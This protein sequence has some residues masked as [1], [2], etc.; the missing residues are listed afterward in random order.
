MQF[1]VDHAKYQL[2]QLYLDNYVKVTSPPPTIWPIV[3]DI[4][5]SPQRVNIPAQ[6]KKCPFSLRDELE[7]FYTLPQEDS[8]ACDPIQWFSGHC[9]QFLNLSHLAWDFLEIPGEF[10]LTPLNG[11]T[12]YLAILLQSSA[13]AVKCIFSGGHDTISFIMPPL[14]LRPFGPWCLWIRGFTTPVLQ[15]LNFLIINYHRR[16]SIYNLY[17]CHDLFPML[18][19]IHLYFI[20][21]GVT[22]PTPLKTSL[23]MLVSSNHTWLGPT[24]LFQLHLKSRPEP[25]SECTPTSSGM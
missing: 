3:T 14:V 8:Y 7:G 17:G 19:L 23:T 5:G 20:F 15:L 24:N 2:H 9:S 6:Y 13:V 21:L 1:H 12:N 25:W 11:S 22:L 10:T 18:S 16:I 4:S